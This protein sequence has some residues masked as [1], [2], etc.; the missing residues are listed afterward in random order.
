MNTKNVTVDSS[1]LL[2]ME[3]CSKEQCVFNVEEYFENNSDLDATVWNFHSE[4][5]R[6]SDLSS[7]AVKRSIKMFKETG[8]NCEQVVQRKTPE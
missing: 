2:K 4:Y 1:K 5:S 6:S 7:S 3:R 8:S